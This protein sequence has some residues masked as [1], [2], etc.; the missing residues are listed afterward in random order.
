MMAN[1]GPPVGPVNIVVWATYYASS[2]NNLEDPLCTDTVPMGS[3]ISPEEGLKC[4]ELPGL[5]SKAASKAAANCS[6][7]AKLFEAATCEG[8]TPPKGAA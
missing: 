1:C 6:S 3:T 2:H 7:V 4:G 5:L 8:L